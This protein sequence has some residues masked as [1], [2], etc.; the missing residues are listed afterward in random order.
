MSKCGVVFQKKT[1][2]YVF[3]NELIAL[4]LDKHKGLPVPVETKQRIME[5]LM[6][7]TVEHEDEEK[8][9]KA[10]KNLEKQVN[11]PHGPTTINSTTTSLT[12]VREQ[13]T[14]I[15]GKDDQLVAK[16]LKQG[17][18]ENYKKANLLIQHR[19]NQEARRTEFIC[20]L[21]SELKKIESTME[22]LDEM[23]NSCTSDV[24]GADS[25]DIMQELY[26]TCKGQNEQMARWP[27]FLGDAEP[28]FLGKSEWF[29][30]KNYLVWGYKLTFNFKNYL[31]L[32]EKILIL[33][34]ILKQFLPFK[35]HG[36]VTIYLNFRG[37][38]K[39]QG[40]SYDYTP[41]L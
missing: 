22:L 37:D 20:H 16:L 1:A 3:L 23:L 8:I 25:R 35:N 11:F 9:Q 24:P 2:K 39:H 15:L 17:G 14:S 21:K 27:D 5:C 28:E 34:R 29:N 26:N 13:R 10:Y 33:C 6:L 30:C 4:V 19:F 7:W 40:S 38:T 36:F 18:E 41:S 32:V 31:Y 12:N